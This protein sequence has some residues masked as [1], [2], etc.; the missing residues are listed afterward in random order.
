MFHVKHLRPPGQSWFAGF[1]EWP[2]NAAFR[3]AFQKAVHYG[4][5]DGV[6]QIPVMRRQAKNAA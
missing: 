1:W 6:Y 2:I 4:Q 3:H 5:A